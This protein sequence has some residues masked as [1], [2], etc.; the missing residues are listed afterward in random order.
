MFLFATSSSSL[1]ISSGFCRLF[2]GPHPCFI[3]RVFSLF[4]RLCA[5]LH[6]ALCWWV[7]FTPSFLCVF[8]SFGCA[9]LLVAFVL[10]VLCHSS[11]FVSGVFEVSFLRSGSL[12][13]RY[14]SPCPCVSPCMVP[15]GFVLSVLVAALSIVLFFSLVYT[16]RIVCFGLRPFLHFLIPGSSLL[17]PLLLSFSPLCVSCPFFEELPGVSRSVSSSGGALFLSSLPVFRASAASSSASLPRSIHVH[18][19]RDCW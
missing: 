8:L 7:S 5:W 1:V 14:I 17:V 2:P 19:F 13:S 10:P 11:I 18:S 15:S 16:H 3:S 9:G 6:S 12:R 4:L